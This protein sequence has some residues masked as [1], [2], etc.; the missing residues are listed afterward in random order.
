LS[1]AFP[2][3]NGLKQ[4]EALLPLLFNFVLEYVFRK[5]QE[6]EEE[7]KL[8]WTYQL[9]VYAADVDLLGENINTIMKSTESL[10]M[11]VTGWSRSKHRVK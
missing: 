4:G 1:D 9:L 10:Q 3:Q 2:V 5:V 8:N 6:N 11:L 7:F